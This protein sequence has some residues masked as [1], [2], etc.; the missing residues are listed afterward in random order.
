MPCALPLQGHGDRLYRGGQTLTTP[1]S[2]EAEQRAGWGDAATKVPDQ[3]TGAIRPP[4]Q[5]QLRVVRDAYRD[6]RQSQPEV[7]GDVLIPGKQIRIG[8]PGLRERVC[9]RTMIDEWATPV[10]GGWSVDVLHRLPGQRSGDEQ[11]GQCEHEP[12]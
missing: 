8:Q 5:L 6:P 11:P 1:F 4:W 9:E 12:G 3:D 10:T 7:G 2:G